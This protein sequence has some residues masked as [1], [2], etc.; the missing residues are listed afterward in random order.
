MNLGYNEDLLPKFTLNL[1]HF[2][3]PQNEKDKIKYFLI[4]NI[5]KE[6]KKDLEPVNEQNIILDDRF[7][8]LYNLINY[9]QKSI[10]QKT[11]LK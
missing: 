6:E 1:L 10:I 9:S 7:M 3:I 8:N 11:I 2:V 4:N 5:I